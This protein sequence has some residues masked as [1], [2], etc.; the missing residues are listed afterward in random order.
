MK[1]ESKPSYEHLNEYLKTEIEAI[2]I[3][4]N[5][6]SLEVILRKIFSLIVSLC[7]VN[8]FE[9]VLSKEC[10]TR[11]KLQRKLEREIISH[12]ELDL[13]VEPKYLIKS[14]ARIDLYDKKVLETK[15]QLVLLIKSFLA[16]LNLFDS[17]YR[18]AFFDFRWILQFLHCARRIPHTTNL[19]DILSLDYE[20]SL[21]ILCAKSLIKEFNHNGSIKTIEGGDLK[22][23]RLDILEG[24]LTNILDCTEPSILTCRD[25]LD[26]FMMDDFFTVI[27]DL[28]EIISILKGPICEFEITSGLKEIA[29]RPQRSHIDS[30][31]RK[32]ILASTF[33]LKGDESVV[34]CMNKILVGF[35]LYGG[36]HLIIIFFFFNIR[37]YYLADCS[38]YSDLISVDHVLTRNCVKLVEEILNDGTHE[39]KWNLAQNIQ[40]PQVLLSITDDDLIMVDEAYEESV[41]DHNHDLSLFLSAVK[42]KA[43]RKLYG[44]P[45][46]Q[47]EYSR[48]QW[49]LGLSWVKFWENCYVDNKGPL[50]SELR[51][52]VDQFWK[53][54]SLKDV[55]QSK[56][57]KNVVD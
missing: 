23:D 26:Y 57:D 20:R 14:L 24:I 7:P 44:S 33:K 6:A 32:Y 13:E 27:G 43:K 38:E 10:R 11:F 46:V 3:L 30:M 4:L 49:N 53:A 55:N 1:P 39:G 34:L 56:S 25:E 18:K 45:K 35:L 22:I 47:G 50:P 29:I 12:P 9:S 51:I 48:I 28:E 5:S 37:R 41:H 42:L 40:F 21:S 15:L 36:V 19:K 8:L 2:D 31:I 17:E 54:A 16:F 52:F